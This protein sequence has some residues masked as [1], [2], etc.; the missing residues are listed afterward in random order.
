MIFQK[1]ITVNELKYQVFRYCRCHRCRR[2]NQCYKA[3][4]RPMY[5]CMCVC[6]CLFCD[7]YADFCY[8]ELLDRLYC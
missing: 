1:P 5:I 8:N 3:T 7:D 6:V 2:S 4:S